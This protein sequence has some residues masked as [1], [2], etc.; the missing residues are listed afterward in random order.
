LS[1]S[2]SSTLPIGV[3]FLT[4]NPVNFVEGV[5]PVLLEHKPIAVWL[6]APTFRDQHAEIIAALKDAGK[7]WGLKVFIQI[8]SV[9]TARDA[10]E[11]GCDIL[12]CREQMLAA[13][14]VRRVQV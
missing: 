11:D 13:I 10:V 9:Q 14:R 5:I 2:S 1:L 4:F 8:G 3:G 12:V 7:V 6:F